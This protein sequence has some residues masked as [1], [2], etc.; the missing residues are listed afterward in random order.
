[1][2]EQICIPEIF[3]SDVFNETTMQQRLNRKVYDA[4]KHC[5][6]TGTPLEL[7]NKYTG[8]YITMYS[9][10]EEQVKKLGLPYDILAGAYRLK[11]ANTGVATDLIT[12]NPELFK[13][14]EITKGKMDDVFLTVTGKA[15]TGDANK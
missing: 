13:D 12:A 3:G 9:I 14:F 5:I 7:K 11:V 10:Q 8:D 1:M 4:W 15:L 2:A 6:Q